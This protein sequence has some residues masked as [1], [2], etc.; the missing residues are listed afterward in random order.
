MVGLL[1]EPKAKLQSLWFARL[2][3]LRAQA[4]RDSPS[5]DDKVDLRSAGVAGA[6][7]FLE[8]PVLLDDVGPQKPCRTS[9]SSTV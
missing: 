8:P 9:T 2:Q 1:A 4:L 5:Q 6:G 3:E 7:G